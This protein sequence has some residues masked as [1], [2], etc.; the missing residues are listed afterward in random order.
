MH[1]IIRRA[2]PADIPALFA[3][4]TAVR[5]NHMSLAQLA[6]IGVTSESVADMLCKDNVAC[7]IGLNVEVPLGFAMARAALADLF[8]LFIRP[9]AQAKGLGTCLLARAEHWLAHQGVTTA[10]LLTGAEPGLRAASF[11]KSRGWN[12]GGEAPPGDIRFT[13]RLTSSLAL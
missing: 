6:E 7:W 2:A 8:A 11:Y 10:W 1:Y 9:E 5:E 13:K 12:Q 4:R 3:I